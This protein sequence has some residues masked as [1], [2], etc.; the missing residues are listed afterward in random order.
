VKVE[1]LPVQAAV[2]RGFREISRQ[3]VPVSG[4]FLP[5][6]AEAL[7]LN[8]QFTDP[9]PK[10]AGIQAQNFCGPVGTFDSSARHLEN[11]ND[12]VSLD[13]LEALGT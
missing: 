13:F 9:G 5:A 8:A 3:G 4:E 1:G 6:R 10:G 11:A 7:L 12:V 2:F